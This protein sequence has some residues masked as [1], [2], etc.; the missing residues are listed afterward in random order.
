MAPHEHNLST[1]P[2]PNGSTHQTSAHWIRLLRIIWVHR[3]RCLVA[4]FLAIFVQA[5]ALGGYIYSGV[6]LDVLRHTTDPETAGPRWP[7]G[8]TPPDTGDAAWSLM[9]QITLATVIVLAFTLIRA[10]AHFL[11][12]VADEAL[13]QDVVVGL[14]T[15]MYDQLQRMGFSFYDQHETG[16]LINR[17]TGDAQSVR[18]FV[19]GMVVRLAVATASLALFLTYMLQEHWG[20]TLAILTIV[21]IQVLAVW[22][23]SR[24]VRPRFKAMREAIDRL[25]QTIQ[26]SVIGIKVVRGFGREPIMIDRF[27]ERNQSAV[28]ARMNIVSLMSRYMPLIPASAY[29]QLAILLA[30]GGY[31]VRVGPD[32]GGISLGVLWVFL[33]L[34]RRMAEQIDALIQSAAILPE[35]LTGAERVFELIDVEPEITSKPDAYCPEP[36]GIRGR[37]VLENISFAYTP[38][39][40]NDEPPEILSEVSFD[41][42]PGSTVALVGPAGAG[43]STLLSLLPRFY[44]PSDGRILIDGVDIRDWDLITLRSAM[45]V[46]FQEPYLFSNTITSNVAYGDPESEYELVHQAVADAAAIDFVTEAGEGFDTLIGERGINL[47]GGERQRLSLARALL[48]SPPILLLDDTTASV[49]AGTE[50]QIQQSLDRIMEGRTT[51]IIAH[52]LSTLKRADQIVVLERGCV[53]ATGTHDQLVRSNEYYRKSAQLQMERESFEQSH[54]H[55]FDRKKSHTGPDGEDLR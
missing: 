17:V 9:Q 29:L 24:R 19:Q 44:D 49:D 15:R 6:A 39:Q 54:P 52:R 1:A 32:G 25:I 12:R 45:G 23:Y 53:T 34:L 18:Q 35:A 41:V 42:E 47:S 31:L 37:L 27:D 51:I 28:R 21:P 11:A 8:L 46:V 40:E 30:Y 13:I 2:S 36:D 38:T 10:V 16:G 55:L 5:L 3:M 4:L 22:R 43:K 33:S 7:F 26:E 48:L 50:K 14:R 20:L